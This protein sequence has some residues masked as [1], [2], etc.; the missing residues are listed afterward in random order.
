[1][2]GLADVDW[3]MIE[4]KPE[5]PPLTPSRHR[6]SDNS[7]RQWVKARTY[8]GRRDASK[9]LIDITQEEGQAIVDAGLGLRVVQHPGGRRLEQQP[10]KEDSLGLPE[11]RGRFER[12]VRSP[13]V[14][15]PNR[16]YQMAQRITGWH[17]RIR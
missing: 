1:V 7:T 17:R 13:P 16:G 15:I 4:Q 10:P 14:G 11:W 9:T 2:V 8:I 6:C 12:G 3:L 5:L